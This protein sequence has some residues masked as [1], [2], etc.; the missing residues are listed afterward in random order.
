MQSPRKRSFAAEQLARQKRVSTKTILLIIFFV[1]IVV[2]VGAGIYIRSVKLHKQAE[3]TQPQE[4]IRSI[5]VLPFRDMSPEKDQEWFC[6]GMAESILNALTRVGDLK[7]SAQT[8]SFA[9]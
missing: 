5:A 4:P 3:S 9:F 6:D 1:F 8:S 2:I 7:V